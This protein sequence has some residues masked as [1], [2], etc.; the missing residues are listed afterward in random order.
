MFDLAEICYQFSLRVYF[1]KPRI[2]TM[3]QQSYASSDHRNEPTKAREF[4]WW[5]AILVPYVVLSVSIVGLLVLG[6]SGVDG[7]VRLLLALGLL[8]GA[9][10]VHVGLYRDARHLRTTGAEWTPRY[11]WYALSGTVIV[12]GGLLAIDVAVPGG[13][14]G[15]V[16]LSAVGGVYLT[17]PVYLVRR[18]LTAR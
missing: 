11:W 3:T 12:L 16:L 9:G 18:Y 13:I 8:I 2:S 7:P 1:L 10:L 17:A 5:W 14:L 4:R 15:G 6:N